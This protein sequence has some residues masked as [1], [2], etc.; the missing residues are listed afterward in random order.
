MYYRSMATCKLCVWEYVCCSVAG[1]QR[2]P[3]PSQEEC[4]QTTRSPLTFSPG[5]PSPS[6]SLPASHPYCGYR[7]T[8]THFSL[9]VFEGLMLTDGQ[10]TGINNS[11]V[12][13]MYCMRKRSLNTLWRY[14]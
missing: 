9:P 3:I 2:M 11:G 12:M 1:L 8:L 6:L 4:R 5:Q 7:S 13:C 10:G 14:G